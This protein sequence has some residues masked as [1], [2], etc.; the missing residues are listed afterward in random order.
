MKAMVVIKPNRNIN[1]LGSHDVHCV[2]GAVTDVMRPA[3]SY[4]SRIAN[5]VDSLRIGRL[6]VRRIPVSDWKPSCVSFSQNTLIGLCAVSQGPTE[7]LEA[8]GR[9]IINIRHRQTQASHQ[10]ITCVAFRPK[11]IDIRWMPGAKRLGQATNPSV[12]RLRI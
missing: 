7:T 5:D 11:P 9:H 4:R 6:P 3:H 1:P 8:V 12:P 10:I 2:L